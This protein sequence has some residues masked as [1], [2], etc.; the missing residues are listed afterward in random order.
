MRGPK[1]SCRRMNLN[2]I[3]ELVGREHADYLL[4]CGDIVVIV[5]EAETIKHKDLKQ[6]VSTYKLLKE[7]RIPGI[8]SIGRAIGVLHR[9][10]SVD[11]MVQKLRATQSRQHRIPII[12]ATCT[13][14]LQSKINRII[15][16]RS[17]Q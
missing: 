11:P 13:R 16:R 7:G 5:E 8:H 15:H 14:D 2:G 12:T 4:L 3:P 9:R 17:K 1:P 10:R 6:V